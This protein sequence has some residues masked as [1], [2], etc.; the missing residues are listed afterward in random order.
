MGMFDYLKISTNLLPLSE[1]EKMEI[2]D[3]VVWHTKDVNKGLS[4][5]E[6]TDDGKL[7]YLEIEYVPDDASFLKVR[8]IGWIEIEMHGFVN[9]YGKV[10][11]TFY[12]FSAKFTDGNLVSI[13]RLSNQNSY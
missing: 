11:D 6:I 10:N 7:R 9:F 2:G 1:S 12:E 8:E 3:N 5:A 4:T 13:T